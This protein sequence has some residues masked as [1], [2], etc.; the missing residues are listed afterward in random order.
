MIII[1]GKFFILFEAKF[2]SGFGKESEKVEGQ[3]IRELKLGS[4]EATNRTKEFIYVPITAHYMYKKNLFNEIPPEYQGKYRWI[5]WQ[6]VALLLMNILED[7]TIILKP[8]DKAFA[9]DLYLLL[10]KKK[11]RVFAGLRSYFYR[12]I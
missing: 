2:S 12:I 11:L 9:E 4:F 10:I 5:N 8:G 1:V 3:I 6:A 7:E